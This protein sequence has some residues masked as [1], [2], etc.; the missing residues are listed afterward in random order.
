MAGNLPSERCRHYGPLRRLGGMRASPDTTLP[1]SAGLIRALQGGPMGM[2]RTFKSA[3]AAFMLAVGFAGS[4]AAGPLEDGTAAYWDER[5]YATALRLLHPLAGKGD[6][7]AQRT[8]GHM[9]RWGQGVP[10]DVAASMS[11]YHKAA[12]QGN[13]EAQYNLGEIYSEGYG[14]PQDYAAGASWYRKAAEQGDPHARFQLAL[15]YEDGDGVPQDYATAHMWLNLAA[16]SGYRIAAQAR[17]RV[18][19]KMTPAQI[20]EAQKL[21]REWKLK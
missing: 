10:R 20:A 19:S 11:W 21:A 16:A 17:D 18:A 14:V 12:E 4:T 9:Y 3:V 2:N 6:S 8:L 15:M 13:S 5:D 1:F 7:E